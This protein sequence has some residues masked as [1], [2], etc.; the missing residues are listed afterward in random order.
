MTRLRLAYGR[1]AQETNA[2]SPVPTTIADFEQ[3]V[4][5]EGEALAAACSA[6]GDEAPGFTRNAE[7]SG[8]VRSVERARARH[9]IEVEAIPT[10]SAWAVPGGPLTRAVFDDLL[11]RLV[12]RLRRA[13]TLDGV[14]LSLHG[15]LGVTGVRDPES[16]ILEAVRE[17][18]SGKPLTVTHD[19]HGNLTSRRVAAADAIVAYRTN[20]HR[21]H[22]KVGEEAGDLLVRTAAGRIRPMSA[23][24]SLPMLVG[25]GTTLDFLPPMVGAYA[26]MRAMRRDPRVLATSFYGCHMWNDD[27][28]LGWSSHVTTDG[29]QALAEELADELAERLWAMRLQLPPRFSSVGEAIEEA[30][31]ATLARKMGV[32][33]FSDASDVVSAGGTGENPRI[34]AALLSSARDLISYVPMRDPAVV[35]SLWDEP[36]GKRVSVCVSG[37]LDPRT[38]PPFEVVGTI[39]RTQRMH[40]FGRM[41]VLD[42]GPVKLVLTELAAFSVK[43]AFYADVG[44]PILAADIVVVKNFFPFRLFYLP[45]ARKTIYVKT[46]GITDVDASFDL[47][48]ID[49]MYPRD[50]VADWRETDARRRG[51][52]PRL[53]PNGELVADTNRM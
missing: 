49:P 14:F 15:A 32:V 1:I 53:A 46:K 50:P 48:F 29:D 19:L 5:M 21:D 9:G 27:P 4:L 23:W 30:R 8:F 37:K 45:Y 31:S 44:L 2:L 26:R 16:V 51:L 3:G 11:G 47:P 41:V 52:A 10:I 22:V 35:A 12:E 33:V 13:G 17:A 7:L 25:G 42:L 43:P 24:R 39:L 36:L 6:T 20:P 34:L 18:T 28:E 40:G 38:N